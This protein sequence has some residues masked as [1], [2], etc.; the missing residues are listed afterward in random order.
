MKKKITVML[1]ILMLILIYNMPPVLVSSDGILVGR[2]IPDKAS[3][4]GKE[5][6]DVLAVASVFS[7]ANQWGYFYFIN[8][9]PLDTVYVE[10]L[11][12]E[13]SN[14]GEKICPFLYRIKNDPEKNLGIYKVTRDNKKFLFHFYISM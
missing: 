6:Y 3:A 1:I 10:E 13:D 2:K 7:H 9:K 14:V 12:F 11:Y 8:T 5:I 4:S